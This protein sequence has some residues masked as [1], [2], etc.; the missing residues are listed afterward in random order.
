MV[1]R[2]LSYLLLV[3]AVTL[4]VLVKKC[5]LKT[6]KIINK[7]IT[8]SLKKILSKFHLKFLNL[9][10]KLYFKNNYI[11]LIILKYMFI[12][13]SLNVNIIFYTILKFNKHIN[14]KNQ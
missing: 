10:K 6:K 12:I 14:L 13:S 3:N 5:L 4:K 7:Q 11:K 1:T 8:K 2:V 9:T